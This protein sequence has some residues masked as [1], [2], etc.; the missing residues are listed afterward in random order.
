MFYLL[1]YSVEAS[2]SPP[3]F[4]PENFLKPA[5]TNPNIITLEE[6]LLPPQIK[7]RHVKKIP[8]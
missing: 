4:L 5:V 8:S 7:S 3:P 2:T 1:L 6:A